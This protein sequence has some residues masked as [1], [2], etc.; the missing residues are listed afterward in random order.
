MPRG[1]ITQKSPHYHNPQC[2][3]CGN[4]LPHHYMKCMETRNGK[5]A[6]FCPACWQINYKKRDEKIGCIN[7]G[8]A[9]FDKKKI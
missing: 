9:T 6:H 3:V 8:D 2:V 7:E 1:N 5:K 4:A